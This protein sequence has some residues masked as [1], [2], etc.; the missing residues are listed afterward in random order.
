MIFLKLLEAEPSPTGSIL[1]TILMLV[2][3]VAVFFFMN[4]S[5]KKQE[6]EANDMR[7]SLM[8]GDEIT[9]IGGIIGRVV[10]VTEETVVIETS[11]DR[12]KLHILKSAIRSVDVHAA[13]TVEAAEKAEK[14]AA[15]NEEKTEK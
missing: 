12:T 15:K 8:M 14:Q 10:K 4:R 3:V 6:R 9:T 13:D 5:Q 7:N 1:P 2:A 11:K